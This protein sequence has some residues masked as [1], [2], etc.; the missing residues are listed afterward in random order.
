MAK[1]KSIR[2]VYFL[3]V[4][5]FTSINSFSQSLEKLWATDSILK[6]PESVLFDAKNERLFVSNIDGKGVWD[7]DRKGSISLVTLT[8]KVLNPQWITG[9]HAPKGMALYQTILIVADVDSLVFIEVTRAAVVK[10]ISIPGAKGLND[11][12]MD[13]RGNIFVTDSKAKKIYMIGITKLGV[14][15]YVE[16]L[17]DPNGICVVDKTIYFIDGDGFYK[18]GKDKEKILIAKGLEGSP[19]GI[20]QIDDE[21]FLV[22]CWAG[23]I[24][25]IKLN[26]EKKLLIDTSK[27][28]INAADIG[29]DKKN[30]VVFVPTFWKN[31][32]SAYQLK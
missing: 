21:T 30:K 17:D 20:E 1:I 32:V 5:F 3:I 19:D 16:G 2:I 22:S 10:K 6:V 18:L 25:Q 24:W 8:G 29:F 4:C 11:V 13:K 26:G 23:M 14:E 15:T 9:L 27:D 7:K 12:A 31:F 28:S